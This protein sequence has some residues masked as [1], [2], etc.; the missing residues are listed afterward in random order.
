LVYNLPE[1]FDLGV[2][3]YTNTGGG[4]GFQSFNTVQGKSLYKDAWVVNL[5]KTFN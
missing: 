5:T 4:S 2:R 1:G 3:Y